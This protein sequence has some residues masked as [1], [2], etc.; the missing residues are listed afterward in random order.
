MEKINR[1][2]IGFVYSIFGLFV[3]D[4]SERFLLSDSEWK[5]YENVQNSGSVHSIIANH[6][7]Q[8]EQSEHTSWLVINKYLLIAS[9]WVHAIACK[10]AETIPTSAQVPCIIGV[11]WT[12]SMFLSS[13]STNSPLNLYY[14]LVCFHCRAQ[15]WFQSL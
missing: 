10:E 2:E 12:S 9:K 11:Y 3:Y 1:F 6:S 8:F 7:E 4:D 14:F 13:H 5:C 15:L